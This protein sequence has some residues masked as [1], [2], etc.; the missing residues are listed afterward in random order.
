MWSSNYLNLAVAGEPKQSSDRC[1]SCY[2]PPESTLGIPVEFEIHV[3]GRSHSANGMSLPSVAP[4][5]LPT[6][7]GDLAI[8]GKIVPTERIL[9]TVLR[10]RQL[11]ERGWNHGSGIGIAH[12]NGG[13][14]THG[15]IVSRS[16]GNLGV[17]EQ[18]GGVNVTIGIPKIRSHPLG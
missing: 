14:T 18:I 16:Q 10:E 9:D 17:T 7:L 5:L 1:C 13:D 2:Q 4:V 11:R 15:K 6:S 3:V 12:G 8:L